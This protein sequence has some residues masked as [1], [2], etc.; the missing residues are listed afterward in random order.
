MPRRPALKE[1]I[2]ALH[3]RGYSNREIAA[4]AECSAATVER[5]TPKR[6]KTIA[7]FSRPTKTEWWV[8]EMAAKGLTAAK[9]AE[10][11]AVSRR[12]IESH[13]A[14]LFLKS[15]CKNR[16]QLIEWGTQRGYLQHIDQK[17]AALTLKEEAIDSIDQ[18]LTAALNQIQ[19]EMAA[20][21]KAKLEETRK[22]AISRIKALK[23]EG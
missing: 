6:K 8:L 21:L 11:K 13:I 18:L 19:S 14:T 12:T 22:M 7:E 2:L 3:S 1:E 10:L 15:G 17:P 5:H 23:V 16:V 9:M 4:I 20:L